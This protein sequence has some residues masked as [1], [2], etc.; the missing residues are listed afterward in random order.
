MARVTKKSAFHQAGIGPDGTPVQ[1]RV[2]AGYLRVSTDEQAKSGLGLGDQRHKIA[3]M[4][5]VKGW[6]EP[7]WYSDE[8]ISGAKDTT[9]RGELARL[10][11][12]L[13]AGRVQAVITLDISRIARKMKVFI[14]FVEEVKAANALFVSCKETFDTSTPQGQFAL[15]LFALVAQLEREMIRERI[16]AAVGEHDRRDGERGGVMPYGYRREAETKRILIE[17][18]EARIIRRVFTL[19]RQGMTMRAI[20]EELNRR[21]YPSPRGKTWHHSSVQVVLK[22]AD[23]YRGGKR[24]ASDLRWPTILRDEE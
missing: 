6:P 14:D 10:M 18:S 9:K 4:A 8:G 20:A 19:R 16:I 12:D 15:Y 7:V 5:A 3:A 22:S 23:Y 13:K 1:V 2:V 21:H 11:A 24:G 17:A